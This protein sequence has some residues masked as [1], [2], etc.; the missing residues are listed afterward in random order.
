MNIYEKMQTARIRLQSQEIRK[1][2]HNKFAGYYYM[3]LG[4]LLPPTQSLFSELKLFGA[5]S[6]SADTAT[7]TITDIEEPEKTIIFT[8]PMGSANLKG[9]HEVQNIGAVETYQRRYLWVTAMEIVEHDAL[10]STTGDDKQAAKDK[11][12]QQAKTPPK[13]DKQSAPIPVT[14]NEM[15]I[16]L[17]LLAGAENLNELQAVFSAIWKRAS[18]EQQGFLKPAYDTRKAQLTPASFGEQA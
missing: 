11:P 1:S 7:L 16:T 12:A 6:Y 5:V 15:T 14:E 3:E 18:K 9:C 17:D 13:P 8:S 2:G 4:D 10:D